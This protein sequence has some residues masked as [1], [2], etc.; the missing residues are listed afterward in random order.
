MRS[1]GQKKIILSVL[2]FLTAA[3]CLSLF[4]LR[5]PAQESALA[6]YQGFQRDAA[7][8]ERR[9]EYDQALKNYL[10]M[11]EMIPD[12]PEANYSV[13]RI[14]ALLGD[15]RKALESL[16]KALSLGYPL[17]G[18]L[19][20]SFD[21]LKGLPGFLEIQTM[22]DDLQK[23]IGRS[24]IA[25]TIPE[26]DLLPEGIAYDPGEDCFYLGSLWK[27]KI[28][29]ID[30]NGG[31]RELATEKQD[32]LRSVA[33]MKVDPARRILWVVSFVSPP[34]AKIAP[35]EVGWSA[36]FKYDLRT[37]KL[38]KKYGLSSQ[39]TGHLFNDL[40]ITDSGDVFVTDSLRGEI[41][42]IFH[43]ADSLEFFFRSD[44]FMY[45]NGITMGKDNQALYVASSGN[46]VFQIDIPTKECR[47]VSHS[48]NIT[49]SAVDGLYF[50]DNSL[51]GIQ[52]RYNRVCRFYMNEKGD[53]VER[54]EIIEA[55]NPLFNFP[56]TGTIAGETFYYIAN[57]QAYSLNPD[58]TLFPLEKLQD[59][60]ILCADL[61]KR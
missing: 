8:A 20:K 49:L 25:F 31:I 28:L 35:E 34:W 41:Y 51:I 3:L 60:V 10:K 56:T 5:S 55:R 9:G 40:T 45:T 36:V 39:E 12:K 54:L 17:P 32:G 13:A 46:G 19:D 33:G 27:G 6:R 21:V 14:H 7:E 2:G 15:S 1:H 4:G 58:G 53:G 26:K 38:I 29:K 48:E 50:I 52:P 30:R 47:L 24:R 44:E 59:V 11:L 16:E 37:G 18:G 61:R 57:S 42:A 23:T 43:Q 22:I